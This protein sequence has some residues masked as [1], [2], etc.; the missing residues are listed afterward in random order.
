MT[1]HASGHYAETV[2]ADYLRTHG[3]VVLECNWRHPRA[4]IDVVARSKD[5]VVTFFEVKHRSTNRQGTGLDY[6][7]SAKLRQMMFAAELWVAQHDFGGEYTLGAI[8]LS[9]SAYEV[10]AVLEDIG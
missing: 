10:T 7:T 5:G 4:E 1:N 3:Y 8:E 2:A 6:I 9:G